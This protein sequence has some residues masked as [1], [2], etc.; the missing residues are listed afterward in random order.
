M[1]KAPDKLT[2]RGQVGIRI[3]EMGKFVKMWK[4]HHR[5]AVCPEVDVRVAGH[6]AK[7]D[8]ESKLFFPVSGP[9]ICGHQRLNVE[10]GVTNDQLSLGCSIQ[11]AEFTEIEEKENLKT[12]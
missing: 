7:V 6:L 1:K 10:G 5:H 2:E 3:E 11:Q 9:D 12:F 4:S 8:N